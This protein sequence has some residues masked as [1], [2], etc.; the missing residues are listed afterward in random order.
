MRRFKNGAFFSKI[1]LSMI[2]FARFKRIPKQ[3]SER[4]AIIVS[5][6]YTDGENPTPG[7]E[8]S[9]RSAAI[10]IFY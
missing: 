2:V 10:K 7:F 6:V 9:R 8:I 3:G 4:Y 1:F 5:P